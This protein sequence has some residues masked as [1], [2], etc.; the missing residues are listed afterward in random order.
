[1]RFFSSES[2]TEKNPAL[3]R[4]IEGGVSQTLRI[5]IVVKLSPRSELDRQNKMAIKH[6][7]TMTWIYINYWRRRVSSRM[8]C[9]H[10]HHT[11]EFI[12]SH[13]V[14]QPE[15]P[16]TR[17]WVVVALGAHGRCQGTNEC[18]IFYYRVPDF[19][20]NVTFDL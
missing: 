14:L 2:G 5:I 10:R 8:Q 20:A 12:D 16:R 3:R 17:N 9:L 11:K 15:Y 1:M 6:S 7:Y 19:C 4:H 13:I 18:Q